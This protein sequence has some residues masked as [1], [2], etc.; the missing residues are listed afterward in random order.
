MHLFP[1]LIC[2]TL[3]LGSCTASIP[4]PVNFPYSQQQKM[5]ASQHWQVLAQDLANRINNELIL[6][7]HI[8]SAV[9]IKPACSE[10]ASPCKSHQK[11][12]FNEAFNDLLITSMVN[13]GIPTRE[14]MK[15]NTL[16]IGYKVQV[17]HHTAQRIRTLQPGI[18]TAVSAAIVVLRDAPAELLILAA[19]VM[20]DIANT[21]L[22]FNGQYEVIITT[23]I[24]D[25]DKYLFRA[26]DIYY[27]NDKD[28]WQYQDT[29]FRAKTIQL[30]T[31]NNSSRSPAVPYEKVYIKNHEL[32]KT[33]TKP[34]EDAA[35]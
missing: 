25:K 19:G 9:Y 5:Q 26:S 8:N 7:D 24:V 2:A 18:L 23:S 13:Y 21:N 17:V 3:L 35:I 4:E 16:E 31:G 14:H 11:S 33:A 12:S 34:S 29:A 32:K 15:K 30:S 20:A 28:F 27:I 22:T 1:V 10:N 6:T